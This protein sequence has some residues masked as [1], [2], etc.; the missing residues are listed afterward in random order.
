M[1]GKSRHEGIYVGIGSAVYAHLGN[2]GRL[3]PIVAIALLKRVLEEA[4][5]LLDA[6]L[7]T[8]GL[9]TAV[10]VPATDTASGDG[11]R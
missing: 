1:E 10:R 9:R 5:E 6:H 8:P 3:D 2:A 11:C 4:T 7:R